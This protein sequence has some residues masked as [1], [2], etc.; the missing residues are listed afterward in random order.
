MAKLIDALTSDKELA[1]LA[2][3]VNCDSA[4]VSRLGDLSL[5]RPSNRLAGNERANPGNMLWI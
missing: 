3:D 4:W 1:H 2:R 5:L